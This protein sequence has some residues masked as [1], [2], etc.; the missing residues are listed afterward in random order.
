MGENGQEGRLSLRWDFVQQF[1]RALHRHHP[2][3]Q[4]GR[5]SGLGV[6]M[7]VGVGNVG[8]DVKDGGAIHQVRSGHMEHRPF[9]CVQLHPL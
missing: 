2:L 4:L 8:L 1:R 7:A 6:R 9:R 3:I 5:E